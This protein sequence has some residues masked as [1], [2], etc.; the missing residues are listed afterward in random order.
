MENGVKT[1]ESCQGG[2]EHAFKTPTVC[3]EGDQTEGYRVVTM[4]AQVNFMVTGLKHAWPVG[5]NE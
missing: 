3:F 2:R 5:N 1:F 4:L